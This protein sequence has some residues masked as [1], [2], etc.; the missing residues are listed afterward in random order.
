[1]DINTIVTHDLT[2]KFGRQTAVDHLTLT[3]PEH[4]IFA[5][6]GPNGAG[7]TT[8]IKMLMNLIVPTSGTSSLLGVDSQHL[9][10]TTLRRIGYVSENQRLPEWMSVAGFLAYCK[11]M[12]P[13]WD[14]G[15][16]ARLLKQFDLPLHQQLKHLSRGM[17][18]KAALLSSLAYHPSLLLLDEPFTGLDPLVRDEFIRGILDLTEAGEWSI[19]ISSHDLN[20]VEQLA[21]SVGFID[22]GKLQLSE[23]LESLQGRCRM[24][25]LNLPAP[26]ATLPPH[27]PE[28]WRLPA[29]QGRRVSIFETCYHEGETE[30]MARTFFPAAEVT[31]ATMTLR[32]IF[33]ALAQSY[34]HRLEE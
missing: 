15:F 6:L 17:K 34:G 12:Y 4:G 26:S 25:E 2:K 23:S 22:Q 31:A 27:L 19:F 29:N 8:T 14:D 24:L 3:I 20:E 16:C 7:K 28:H 21:D 9:D 18:V 30:S 5:F 10:P 11:T 32:E 13:D 33:V 1:M